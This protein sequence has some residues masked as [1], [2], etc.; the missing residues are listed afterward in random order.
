MRLPRRPGILSDRLIAVGFVVLVS[1]AI[2]GLSAGDTGASFTATTTNPSNSLNTLN[3]LPPAS[4]SV[5]ASIAAGTVNL[6]WTATPTSP[7]AHT[8]TYL[9]FRNGTQVGSTASLTFAD[10]PPADGTYAYTIQAKVAQG[11]GFF[12]SANSASQNGISDRL[13]PTMSITCAAGAC[14][15]WKN[16]STVAV[17][18]TDAG[19]GMQ[20]VTY[21]IDA[22]SNVVTN[23]ST[24]SFNPTD[25]THTITYFGTDVAG[26][27]QG[28]A[29]QTVKIDTVAPTAVTGLSSAVGAGGAPVTVDLAWTA[30]TD[31]TSGVAG[32][33][34]HWSNPVAT[35]A[36]ATYPNSAAIGV[37]TSY[38][39]SGLVSGSFYCAYVVT[40]DNAGNLSAN[41]AITGPTK[42][43]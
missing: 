33:V 39:I 37:V 15:A 13:A 20:S 9:V 32:Y 28:N 21:K 31:A 6:A 22:G 27:V 38:Q 11:A 40:Q 7:G 8:L 18:G 17:T 24:V 23:A 5:P 35:C 10:T 19:S 29:T 26:N 12:T 36:G 34:V 25:G 1:S 16:S 43:K 30:G 42:A 14:G 4:Q 3:L 41:S 2:V